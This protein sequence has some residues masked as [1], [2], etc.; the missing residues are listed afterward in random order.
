MGESG[1]IEGVRACKGEAGGG[2][3]GVQLVALGLFFS[4]A[5]PPGPEVRVVDAKDK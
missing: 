4:S 1:G 2:G 5:L 3:G